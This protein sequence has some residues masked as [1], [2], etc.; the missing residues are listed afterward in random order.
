MAQGAGVGN[1]TQTPPRPFIKTENMRR[2][3]ALS[4][5]APQ[6]RTSKYA[7]I[8]VLTTPCLA[9]ILLCF[10]RLDGRAKVRGAILCCRSMPLSHVRFSTLLSGYSRRLVLLASCSVFATA[11]STVHCNATPCNSR[12]LCCQFTCYK[13]QFTI[14]YKQINSR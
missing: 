3:T 14:C 4:F 8:G 9:C 1:N 2:N 5:R 13:A 6:S 12:Q 10:Y 7:P 11:Y